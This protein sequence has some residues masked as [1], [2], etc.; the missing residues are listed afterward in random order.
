MDSDS[1]DELL[2]SYSSSSFLEG[3]TF[4]SFLLSSFPFLFSFLLEVDE[5]DMIA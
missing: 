5:E 4:F 2:G 3:F 1:G